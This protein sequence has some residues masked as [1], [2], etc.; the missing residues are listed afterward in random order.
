MAISKRPTTEEEILKFCEDWDSK[1][2]QG[3]LLLAKTWGIT[4]GTAKHWRS[5]F[6]EYKPI[7]KKLNVQEA[8]CDTDEQEAFDWVTA[9]NTLPRQVDLDFVSFDLE[10]TNLTANFSIIL[11]AS[12]KPF[13]KE[14]IVFRADEYPEWTSN[15]ANDKPIVNDIA[16]ELRKHAIIMTHYGTGFDIPYFRAKMVKHG[17]PPLPPMFGLDTY[18]IAKANF[19]IHSRRLAALG[20]YFNIGQKSGVE[21]PLWLE[22]SLSGS[23]EAMDSIVAHNIQDVI[24]LER[25]AVLSFPYARSLRRL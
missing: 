22:A 19:K 23:T 8:I 10:T 4:Y 13:G 14:T 15:R 25:L 3:K 5:D 12:I 1:N 20:D 7:A 24:L 11:T 17:L 2:K 9:I 6:S 18:A 21:G 16:R